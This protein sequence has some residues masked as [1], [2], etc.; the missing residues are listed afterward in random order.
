MSLL[1]TSASSSLYKE[2]YA[3]IATSTQRLVGATNAELTRLYRMVL[4]E[5][6]GDE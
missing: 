3:L 1:S 4:L 5:G 6:S 2:L